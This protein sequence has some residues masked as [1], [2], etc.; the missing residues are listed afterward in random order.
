VLAAVRTAYARAMR[1]ANAL[2]FDDLLL[3]A[4]RVFDEH[5]GVRDAYARRFRY[6]LVDEY[7]DTNRAQYLLARHLASHHRNLAVCGDPDQSIYGWRGAEPRNIVDFEQDFG[8]PAVVKLEQNYRSAGNILKA[9]QAVIRHNAERKE[10]DLW[11][12]RGDG[13]KLAVL[14][15]VDENDEA[16]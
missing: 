10:K 12:D 1:E 6:V 9:A 4:L 11:T 3:V 15:C 2:D 16:L 5:P 7:Q 8:R 14:E 13:E